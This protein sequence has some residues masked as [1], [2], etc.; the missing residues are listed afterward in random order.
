MQCY[1]DDGQLINYLCDYKI[2]ISNK[3]IIK[4]NF[5]LNKELG[6]QTDL[7]EIYDRSWI[8]LGNIEKNNGG[9]WLWV[10]NINLEVNTELMVIFLQ[11]KK[12][13]VSENKKLYFYIQSRIPKIKIYAIKI[14]IPK[15]T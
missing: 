15:I 2:D 4:I 10:S 13:N 11:T 7:I 1:N 14:S 8:L 9:E 5:K 12:I 6:E 3:Q